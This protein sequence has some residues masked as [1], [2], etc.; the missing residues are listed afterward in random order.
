MSSSMYVI[1]FVPPDE[2]WQRMADIYFACKR[3]NVAIPMEVEDF[4][5]GG[6]P[7]AHGQEVHIPSRGWSAEMREGIEIDV[8]QIPSKVKTIRFYKSY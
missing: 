3:A 1:G 8:A 6:E 7:D 2:K 4:F 5:D